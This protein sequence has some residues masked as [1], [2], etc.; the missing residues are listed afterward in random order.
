MPLQD[1][2]RGAIDCASGVVEEQLLLLSGHLPEEIAWLLP[3]IILYAVVIVTSVAFERERR[4]SV[5]RLVVP[6]SLAIRVISRRRSQVSIC[7]HLAIAVIG[8]EWTLRRVNRDVIEVNT[9][10]VSLGISVREQAALEH[11][12]RRETNPGNH[13]RLGEGSL[14]NLCEVV[15]RI[16]I[17]LHYPN[18]DQWVVSLG[19][20]FGQ[21]KRIVLM[22]LCLFLGHY[23]DEQRPTRKISTA[24]CLQ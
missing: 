1:L 2:L 14:L 24:D 5:F 19:P 3:V 9:E 21:I 13:I 18:F 6:Q 7:A 17:E 12:V 8:V 23:L 4:L 10:A 15:F 22:G 11:L 20:D 16:T